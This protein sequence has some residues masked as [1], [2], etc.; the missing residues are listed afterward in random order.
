MIEILDAPITLQLNASMRVLLTHSIRD[1]IGYP[2]LN[3]AG[4]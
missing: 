1:G 2:G 4:S 3:V